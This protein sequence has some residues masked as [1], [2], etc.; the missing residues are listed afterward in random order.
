[1]QFKTVPFTPDVQRYVLEHSTPL[2][3]VQRSL[4][5]RSEE[6]FSDVADLQISPEQ[7]PVLTMLVRLLGAT[8]AVE[9]GTFTGYSALCIAR[10]LPSDGHLLCCDVSETWTK[11]AREAW[12]TGAVADRI[13]LRIA[14]AAETLAELP[15]S[16]AIDFAFVDA[17]KPGYWNYHNLLMAR[18]RPGGLIAYDNVLY[19]G[20]V[21]N[22]DARGPAGAMREFNSR[23]AQDTRV[24][25]ALLPFADGLTLARKRL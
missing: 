12:E 3:E 1:M 5:A 23:I 2:D 21:M 19:E 14:P 22:P 7:G 16:P 9:V 4:I 11:V 17:D 10:G 25:L 8:R 15:L 20:D 24:E 6:L 13:E 18:L